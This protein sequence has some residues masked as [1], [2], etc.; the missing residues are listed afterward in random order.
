MVTG[1]PTGVATG[2]GSMPGTLARE[3]ATL[4]FGELP[5]LPHLVEL[6]ERGPGADLVGRGAGLLVDVHVDFQPSG[7]RLVDRAGLDERRAVSWLDED[8]DAL[9]E[10]AEGWTGPLKMQVA[11]PWTLA[12][13]LELPR[14]D[15]ALADP[16][17]VRDIAA[18]LAAAVAGHVEDVQRRVPGA[19]VLV[20]LDEPSRPATLA[21]TVKRASGWGRL[22]PV[23]PQVVEQALSAVVQAAGVPVGVHC[24]AANVPLALVRRAGAS[25]VAFDA[26]LLTDRDEDALGE[27]L[28]AGTV[29]G[30]GLV[31]TRGSLSDPAGTVLP[32]RRLGERLGLSAQALARSVLLTPGCGLAGVSPA[33]ARAVLARARDA[34][35]RLVEDAQG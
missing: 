6:P 25:M 2:V 23:E 21:G 9:E 20:Q 11:G 35:R 13:Q 5:E 14:G 3:A 8:L 15:K 28:E 31:P 34:A 10:A 33:H 24:C 18:S 16:G 22:D 4:I 32:L 29:L 17:A 27:A 30:F 7:W 1:W 12:A 26:A 19:Q